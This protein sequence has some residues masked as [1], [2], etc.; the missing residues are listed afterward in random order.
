MLVVLGLSAVASFAADSAWACATCSTGDPT[1]TVTGVEKPFMGRTR[2]SVQLQH[3]TESTGE[4]GVDAIAIAEQRLELSAAHAATDWLFLAAKVPLV[5]RSARYVNLAR[6]EVMSLGDLELRAKAFVYQD[7]SLSARHLVALNGGVALPTA[8]LFEDDAGQTLP[9]EAQA[10]TGALSALA[11]AS[12]AYFVA[13]F[14][15]YV[16]ANVNAP[17]LHRAAYRTGVVGLFSLAAQYQPFDALA[18]RLSLDARVDQAVE[19]RGA[20][21][22]HSGGVATAV[23]PELVLSPAEDLVL[24]AVVMLPA[25]RRMNGAHDEGVGLL[26]GAAH[27]L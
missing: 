24:R 17:L 12:Y 23:S 3:R 18:L 9:L 6:D 11:G 4:A 27:D 5:R 15:I 2:M 20:V 10:G 13:P 14:S 19:E 1:L 25:Y 26:V 16:S 22:P 7:R 21:D 8:P